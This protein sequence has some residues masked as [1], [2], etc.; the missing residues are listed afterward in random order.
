MGGL[1][2]IISKKEAPKQIVQEET[3]IQA[4]KTEPKKLAKKRMPGS[5][6]SRITGG[7]MTNYETEMAAESTRNPLKRKLGTA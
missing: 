7:M 5:R 4:K 6:R 1:V 2:R 3:V